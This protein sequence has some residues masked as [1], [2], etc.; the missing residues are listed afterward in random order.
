MSPWPLRALAECSPD[1]GH[2]RGQQ[3]RPLVTWAKDLVSGGCERRKP[4]ACRWPSQEE[5]TRL[6]LHQGHEKGRCAAAPRHACSLRHRPAVRGGRAVC[7]AAHGWQAVESGRKGK[8][9]K[10]R[11]CT[12]TCTFTHTNTHTH[13]WKITPS[14][15]SFFSSSGHCITPSRLYTLSYPHWIMIICSKLLLYMIQ[16]SSRISLAALSSEKRIELRVCI[17][18]LSPLTL[19]KCTK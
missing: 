4:T 17:L 9:C 3:Q 10:A 2:G 13:G 18:N 12:L 16:R 1:P 15:L 7:P 19:W 14:F 5:R 8:H 6:T 11:L